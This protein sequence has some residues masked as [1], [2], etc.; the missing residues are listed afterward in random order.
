M[1]IALIADVHANLEALDACLQ[2]AHQA[3]ARHHVFL[4]DLVGYGP[5]PAEVVDRVRELVD[6]GRAQALLG[7]HDE[8]AV[9]PPERLATRLR[10]MH[11]DA[12][13]VL[14]WTAERLDADRAA[15]LRALPL[16]IDTSEALYVHANAWAPAGWAYVA[17]ALEAGRS[18]MATRQRVSFCGHVH[19]PALYH[20]RADGRVAGFDPVPGETIPLVGTRRWMGLPGSCGQPRDGDPA[21]CWALFDPVAGTLRFERTPYDHEATV[22]RLAAAGLPSRLGERLLQGG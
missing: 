11:P 15:F 9:M 20:L 3:G 14:A 21:A 22:A 8:A 16:A 6:A 18:M 2:A 13:A 19:V 7:N 5:Q 12:R 10:G 1:S 4:G 17:S